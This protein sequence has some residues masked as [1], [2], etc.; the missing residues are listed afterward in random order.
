VSIVQDEQADEEIDTAE[1]QAP[2]T[3]DVAKSALDKVLRGSSSPISK[4]RQ[5]FIASST[6][7]C[8]ALKT[9]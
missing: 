7:P 4:L 6:L 1:P 3:L 2:V 9:R 5:G 8:S